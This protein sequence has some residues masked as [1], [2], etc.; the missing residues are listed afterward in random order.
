M[1]DQSKIALDLD[2]AFAPLS[3]ADHARAASIRAAGKDAGET[4]APTLPA[5]CE[6]PE[7][8]RHRQH[9][10]SSARWVYRDA[11][12]APLFAVYRF[13]TAAGGKETFP[14][15]YGTKNG[16][17]GWHWKRPDAP[18][19]L[20]GLDR[21]A[22]C[23]EAPVLVCEGEKAANAAAA[24]FPDH[25]AIT[26]QGGARNAGKTDW[27]P[28]D[29]RNVAIWPDNDEPGTD[30]ARDVARLAQQAGAAEVRVV[31]VPEAFGEGWDLADDPPEPSEGNALDAVRDLLATAPLADAPL[32]LPNGFYFKDGG[33][34]VQPAGKPDQAPPSPVFV[35]AQFDVVAESRDAGGS[36]WGLFIRWRDRDG[37]RHEWAMPRRMVHAEGNAI[38]E[39]LEAAGLTCGIGNAHHYLKTFLAM[40]K[41]KRR[42]ECVSRTGWHISGD[43]PVFVAPWGRTYGGG[44]AGV[45]LQS[46]RLIAAETFTTAGSLRDWQREVAAYAVGNDRLAL[47]VAAAFAGPLL[48]IMNEPSG[49]VHLIGGSQTGKSTCAFAAGSVWGR[50]DR[51]A[52]VRQWRATAN[53]LEAVAAE[54]SD[55]IL[56]L[57]EMGQADPREVGD[58]VYS[59]ANEGGKSRAGRGGEARRRQTWRSLFLSTGELS[60]AAKMGEAGKRSM[61]GLDVRLVSL[62][63]DAGAGLGVFQNLH[64]RAS[65]KELADHL[66]DAA[67]THHGTAARAYLGRLAADRA[68]DTA[69]LRAILDALRRRFIS[70]FC[71]EGADGQ[72]YSVAS[73]FALIGAAGELAR[74]YGVLPWPEGAALRAAGA[75]FEAWFAERGGAGAGEDAAA[76]AQVRAFIEAHGSSRFERLDDAAPSSERVINRV[77]Y[78]RTHNGAAEYLIL[79]ES[80]KGEVCKGLDAK[81]A[82]AALIKAGHLKPDG[83][84]RSAQS[85]R[86]PGH[87]GTCRV[88]LI[89]GSIIGE[90]TA[91]DAGA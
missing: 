84:G 11:D 88:Y 49:G 36:E 66:R 35:A 27:Q 8:L 32:K 7:S 82:A 4:W 25:V 59:L 22:A 40:V 3:E 52:Q 28:L 20:Y 10:A 61:A 12:G 18:L 29:G 17:T 1:N 65:A 79:R 24:I 51:G 54:T 74:E 81:R 78:R 23:P 50:G 48:D 47:F 70:E 33:L 86:L 58:I 26:S 73:R 13:N 76:I 60:L 41:P 42:L 45:I 5:P 68:E 31:A 39:Q 46:E 30:Y 91:T 87:G 90:E 21:L 72:V 62:P 6:P 38:A 57:D 85:V 69:G 55:L 56:I 83:S 2:A 43:K 37:R 19:P 34:Y 89:A 75:C 64:G 15:T 71:P 77:G 16:R 53:G 80:W 9:G 63:A 67:R 44:N 14:Q